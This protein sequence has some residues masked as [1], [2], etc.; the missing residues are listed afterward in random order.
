[1]ATFTGGQNDGRYYI[2]FEV[3]PENGKLKFTGDENVYV[4]SITDDIE[5]VFNLNGAKKEAL[6]DENSAL[7]TGAEKTYGTSYQYTLN[8]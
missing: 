8:Y 7:V 3:D 4:E 2:K 1:M 5:T 6:R